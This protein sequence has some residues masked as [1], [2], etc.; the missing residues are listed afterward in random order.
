MKSLL[1]TITPLFIALTASASAFSDAAPRE[2]FFDQQASEIQFPFRCNE[3]TLRRNFDIRARC[4]RESS[5]RSA[6][7]SRVFFEK[8][9]EKH[10][11]SDDLPM[12]LRQEYGL[13]SLS[14]FSD[15]IKNCTFLVSSN[16]IT[17]VAKNI[18]N[19]S[20][21]LKTDGTSST[22]SL[23]QCLRTV[24]SLSKNYGIKLESYSIYGINSIDYLNS[25]MSVIENIGA[26]YD[27][28]NDKGNVSQ[29]NPETIQS[30][31]ERPKETFDPT[32]PF[33]FA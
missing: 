24:T 32:K 9:T 28:D 12:T 23:A 20:G 11:D 15:L 8:V 17:Q 27:Q 19:P 3:Q 33:N 31:S 29:E 13:Q 25:T 22:T 18:I 4:L 30:P 6:L 5:E 14:L 1:S 21:A 7:I 16:G 26:H 2:D 10:V